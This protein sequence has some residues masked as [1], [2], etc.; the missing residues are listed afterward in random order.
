M[1]S[2]KKIIRLNSILFLTLFFILSS[3]KKD[4]CKQCIQMVSE[5]YEPTRSGYP[6]TTT[7][8]FNS[9]GPANSW[10]GEQFKFESVKLHDT[11]YTKA[12]TTDCK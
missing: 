2:L 6:K 7:S 11:I 12:V 9:C 4:E 1:K 8:T 10:I 5:K 3:C